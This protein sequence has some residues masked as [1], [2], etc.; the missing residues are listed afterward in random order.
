MLSEHDKQELKAMAG[1]AR[2]R[3][4]FALLEMAS[5]ASQAKVSLEQYVRF[6]TVMSRLSTAPSLERPFVPYTIVR[7]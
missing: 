5:R 3:E 2:I 7:I 4:E 1:S 6:L